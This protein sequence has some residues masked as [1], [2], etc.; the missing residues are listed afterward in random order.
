MEIIKTKEE[1]IEKLKVLND[2]TIGFVPTMGALHEGHLSL[3]EKC[4]TEND[5]SVVSIFLNPTQ[6]DN[7]EDLEKYPSS[8]E[9]DISIL[10][11]KNV[12]FLFLPDYDYIY[13]DGYR[14][15]VTENEFSKQL[16]GASR[17]GHFNGVL[18]VV[19]KLFN[20]I[21]PHRAYFGEKDYQQ[22][23]LIEGMVDAFFM[24]V[25]IV[26]CKIIREDDG[27]AMSSR[28]LRLTEDERKIAPKFYQ[29]L[30]SGLNDEETKIKLEEAGF[31][32]D[33]IQTIDDR[34]FGA[35]FLGNVRLIDN[36]QI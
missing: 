22:L 27:L 4:Q 30:S 21:L 14:Y 5:I 15:S 34:K 20:I 6:F 26:P 7:K 24:D 13:P 10:K 28:N 29:I 36:V 1:W 16:C 3:I 2:S 8:I 17:P 11:E 35:V 18:T 31:K 9:D 25:E 19:M 23:K 32:V 12:D 33:Y